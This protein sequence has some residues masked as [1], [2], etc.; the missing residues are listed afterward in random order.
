MCVDHLPY[1][2]I[3]AQ[4]HSVVVLTERVAHAQTWQVASDIPAASPTS[5]RN[6]AGRTLAMLCHQG[7]TA[8]HYWSL[9]RQVNPSSK[10]RKHSDGPIPKNFN[11]APKLVKYSQESYRRSHQTPHSHAVPQSPSFPNKHAPPLPVPCSPQ[12]SSSQA[13]QTCLCIQNHHRSILLTLS[14][15]IYSGLGFAILISSS[16]SSVRKTSSNMV[17]LAR[18][19]HWAATMTF[20]SSKPG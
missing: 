13:P 16:S 2:V 5:K 11:T 1:L 14:S 17:F 15:L 4:P 8:A 18:M 20:H 9:D 6:I 10:Q 19:I 12:A 7:E 3:T